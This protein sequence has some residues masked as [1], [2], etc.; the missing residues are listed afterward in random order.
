[1]NEISLEKI[2]AMARDANGA[3]TKI[4]LHW[5]AGPYDVPFSDY[6]LNI[7]DD[8]IVY[9]TCRSL[10]EKKEHTWHRNTG[11]VGLALCCCEDAIAN[12]GYDADF[13][14]C[15]PTVEQ[16]EK[17][18]QLVAILCSELGLEINKDNVMTHEEAARI[19]GYGPYS[20]DPETRWDLWYLPDSD[21]KMKSGG[22]VIRG[23]AI[24]YLE[25][26]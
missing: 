23:K 14:A 6:H 8:G 4:Y 20:G 11:A 9:K 5:T 1:M 3:I 24:W 12:A 15:P 2:K 25:N 17:L 21:G 7:D 22:D 10:T 19:D 13:G 26:K 16:I 18:S